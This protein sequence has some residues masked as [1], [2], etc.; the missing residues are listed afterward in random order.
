MT[1]E[2]LTSVRLRQLR[3]DLE[4]GVAAALDDFWHEVAEHGTPLIEPADNEHCLV[5]FLWRDTGATTGCVVVQ[6]WGAD[7]LPEHHMTRLPNSNVWFYTRRLPADTRTTYQL[8]PLPTPPD[9][10]HLRLDPLN[11]QRYV[12]YLGEDDDNIEFSLLE[13][14]AALPQPWLS[15]DVPC[16]A[17]N[18]HDPLNDGRRVW[19]YTP[20]AERGPFPLLVFFDGRLYKDLLRVPEML[21]YLIAEGKIPP[22][23]ALLVD[24]VQRRELVCDPAFADYIATQLVPWARQALPI[25]TDPAATL[26]GGS[27]YGGLGAAFCGLQHSAVFGLVLS[28]TGWFRWRPAADPEFE[29][30]ARQYVAAPRLPLRF[31]LDVGSLENA[32]MDDD[33]PNHVVANRHMRDVL[34]A[35]GQPQ[36]Y[37][38]G[39]PQLLVSIIG[40]SGVQ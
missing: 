22:I 40:V 33:G 25:H 5:T 19:V 35:K 37:H 11:S 16:G 10:F 13:L 15:A 23:V 30:L 17:V 28:Q 24:N 4:R 1:D 20:V 12:A 2:L 3:A 29:W 34:Q 26:V 32:R 9:T 38:P 6:D 14:P 39:S 8:W 18:L 36:P 21:D 7:G 27:S 31:Y